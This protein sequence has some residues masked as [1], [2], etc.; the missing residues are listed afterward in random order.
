MRERLEDAEKLRLFSRVASEKQKALESSLEKAQ[1][2]SQVLEASLEEAKYEAK[3]WERLAG[4]EAER[5]SR[6]EGERDAAR[7][8]ASTSRLAAEAAG[9]AKARVDDELARVRISLISEEERGREAKAEI[10]RLKVEYASLQSSLEEHQ[11]EAAVRWSQEEVERKKT[12]EDYLVCLEDAFVYGYG[13]CAFA[14][15]IRNDHPAVPSGMPPF[16]KPLPAGFFED[17]RC[18]PGSAGV[19]ISTGQ[20]REPVGVHEADPLAQ[21]GEEVGV[22]VTTRPADSPGPLAQT[23]EEVGVV[24]TTRPADSPDPLGPQEGER[25]EVDDLAGCLIP[26]C[27][28]V[29]SREQPASGE[30]VVEV[31]DD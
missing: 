19:G 26:A 18:P 27:S 13:C 22:V 14:H 12:K 9:D 4:G 8:E 30:E 3:R 15:N 17:P 21:T 29:S 16:D 11:R 1:A 25:E 24:V 6:A 7:R 23:G 31:D 28:T 20:D 10:A 5:A 2:A